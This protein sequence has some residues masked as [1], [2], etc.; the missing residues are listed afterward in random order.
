MGMNTFSTKARLLAGACFLLAPEHALSHGLI[1]TLN[2]SVE[3]KKAHVLRYYERCISENKSDSVCRS[4]LEALHPREETALQGILRS[5]TRYDQFEVSEAMASCYGQTRDYKEVIECWERLAVKMTAGEDIKNDA[6]VKQTS[7]PA[8]PKGELAGL[9]SA[10]KRSVVLCVRGAISTNYRDTV[11]HNLQ[12]GGND[13]AWA[14]KV[15]GFESAQMNELAKAADWPDMVTYYQAETD[16]AEKLIQGKLSWGGYGNAERQNNGVLK[17]I[18][19]SD[20]IGLDE[21][22]RNFQ[23][24]EAVCKDISS[25]FIVRAKGSASSK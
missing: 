6:S 18:F 20:P 12:K 11:A 3:L 19:D 5:A 2:A 4:E 23:K 10:E 13:T 17:K 15:S 8:D 7:L 25:S 21:H 24:F 16:A 1:E 14:L 22:K 9:T